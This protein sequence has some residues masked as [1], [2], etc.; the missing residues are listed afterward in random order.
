MPVQLALRTFGCPFQRQWLK[1]PQLAQGLKGSKLSL[2]GLLHAAVRTVQIILAPKGSKRPDARIL[3]IVDAKDAWCVL[4]EMTHHG[5][6]EFLQLHRNRKRSSDPGQVYEEQG[7]ECCES[8][9]I[10][11]CT[12]RFTFTDAFKTIPEEIK[13]IFRGV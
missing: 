11:I 5:F 7:C 1:A 3:G 12:R 10:Y 4:P 9:R 2:H 6:L 8:L 13:T